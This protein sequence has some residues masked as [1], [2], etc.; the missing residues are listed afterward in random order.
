[1]FVLDAVVVIVLALVA[2]VA[3][4]DVEALPDR[5]P[6][7]VVVVRLFVLGLYVRFPSE[8]TAVSPVEFPK[9][10]ILYDVDVEFA[11]TDMAEAVPAE[12][13]VPLKF[14]TNVPGAPTTMFS[15]DVTLAPPLVVTF[16]FGLHLGADGI[17]SYTL[18]IKCLL[19]CNTRDTRHVQ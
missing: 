4:V 19:L 7:N 8:C 17:L 15:P 18:Q 6:V 2:L 1:M 3:L 14:P 11:V 16:T 9:N 5:F 12:S 13:A 10:P